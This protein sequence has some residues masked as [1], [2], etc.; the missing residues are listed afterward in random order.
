[1]S[2]GI[3][4]YLLIELVGIRLKLEENMEA[5]NPLHGKTIIQIYN[6]TTWPQCIFVIFILI[7]FSS[8]YP[9]NINK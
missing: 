3:D 9:N 6:L 5:S 2:L 7:V 1:M 4:Y 8:T